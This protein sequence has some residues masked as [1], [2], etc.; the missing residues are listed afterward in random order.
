MFLL[1]GQHLLHGEAL[2][3]LGEAGGAVLENH[4][5]DGILG[6]GKEGTVRAQKIDGSTL[7]DFEMIRGY[8]GTAALGFETVDNG[9][10][11]AGFALPKSQQEPEVARRPVTPVGR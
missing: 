11:I 4:R 8:L 9:W 10:Y 7:P 1:L 2:L 6:E 5:Q 3:R